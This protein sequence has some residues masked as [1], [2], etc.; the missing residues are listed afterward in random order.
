[1]WTTL[2]ANT[3]VFRMTRMQDTW[4][5]V[6]AGLGSYFGRSGR[7]HVVNQATVYA[8]EDPRVALSEW[9][10]HQAL[11]RCEL[12]GLG[13]A[14]NYPL[15]EKGQLWEFQFSTPIPLIDVSHPLTIQKYGYPAHVPTNPHSHEYTA[16]QQLA[17]QI[18]AA[19]GNLPRPEGLRAV[20]LRTVRTAH[21]VP[22]QLVFFVNPAPQVVPKTLHQ[23]ARQ[24]ANWNVELEFTTAHGRSHV[25]PLDRDLK[26][27]NPQFRVTGLKPIPT[28]KGFGNQAIRRNVWH[29]LPLQY[30]PY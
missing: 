2:P 23:R 17:N 4:D 29:P 20:S 5:S 12:L 6:L 18:R 26:W 13:K 28:T 22:E 30:S 9:A 14:L 3:S 8:S 1:M 24:F 10:W 16:T 15:M 25:S 7:Y 27:S 21:S 19:G 11:S